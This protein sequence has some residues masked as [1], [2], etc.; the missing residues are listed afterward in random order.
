MKYLYESFTFP[1]DQSFTVK[2]DIFGMTACNTFQSHV[3][4]E[5]IL[6]E[7][8]RGRS[9]IGNHMADINGPQLALLGSYLPHCWQSRRQ[10]DHTQLPTAYIVHFSPYF[11][12]KEF[13]EM[14]EAKELNILFDKA[15]GGILFTGD[16]II[17]ARVILQQLLEATGFLKIIRMIALLDLLANSKDYTVL[18][19]PLSKIWKTAAQEQRITQV[20]DY[21]YRNFRNT[22]SLEE[23]A[24][25]IHMTASGFCRYLKKTTN[26]TFVEILKDIRISHAAKLLLTGN[27][28][29]SEAC[30]QSGYNN[31]SNFYQHFKEVKGLPP[32][33]FLKQYRAFQEID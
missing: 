31:L 29:I 12:G 26:R 23:V 5:I 2:K 6:L 3:N 10:Q 27:Y 21:I 28:N 15:L 16:T 13:L 7:N 14:P 18:D 20:F 24:A 11:M 8:C 22:I 1:P 30:Y 4:F 33:K 19:S 25:A 17:S 9:L 32:N